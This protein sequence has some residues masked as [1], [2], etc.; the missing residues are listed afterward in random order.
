[1]LYGVSP[2]FY[3]LTK[4]EADYKGIKL[5]NRIQEEE[6]NVKE[7]GHFAYENERAHNEDEQE[8][9]VE[10]ALSKMS[11]FEKGASKIYHDDLAPSLAQRELMNSVTEENMHRLIPANL[12][13]ALLLCL[14]Q[15][16]PLQHYCLTTDCVEE[17]T[18]S[19]AHRDWGSDK[20]EE[21]GLGSSKLA[22]HFIR[23][24]TYFFPP[25]TDTCARNGSICP[26]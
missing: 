4:K 7:N 1:M 17:N 19:L 2:S 22:R 13:C 26:H 9:N 10:F 16:I 24:G 18:S 5:D 14:S 21:E 8:L 23:C 11:L 20:E 15:T 3:Y 6:S 12:L 25:I